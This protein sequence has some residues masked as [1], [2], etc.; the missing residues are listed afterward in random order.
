[1]TCVSVKQ[2]RNPVGPAPGS[3]RILFLS[4]HKQP[5]VSIVSAENSGYHWVAV[6]STDKLLK[7]ENVKWGSAVRQLEDLSLQ[8]ISVQVTCSLWP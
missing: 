1:M 4:E 3:H 2:Q 6:M 5:Q 8:L 7:Q